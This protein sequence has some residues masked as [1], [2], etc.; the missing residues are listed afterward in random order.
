MNT[1]TNSLRNFR[2]CALAGVEDVRVAASNKIVGR[3]QQNLKPIYGPAK[4]R[5]IEDFLN[6]SPDLAGILRFTRKYGPLRDEPVPGAEFE[7]HWFPW[8]ADQRRLR[9][10]WER[11][12]VI[13][14]S[15]WESSGG[16]LACGDGWLTYTTS[17]LYSFLQV[18]L[19]TCEAKRL[20]VCKKPGCK[21][22]CF[23]TGDLKQRFCNEICAAWGQRE[24]KKQWW[25]E[26]GAAWREQRK[27]SKLKMKG[28]KNGA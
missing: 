10:L 17:S 21:N 2:F 23:I 13:Q 16:S 4:R 25:A 9:S 1:P 28:G 7:L 18:D 14:P 15:D 3:F 24:W 26:H 8:V 19:I 20:R 12:R 11:R 22:P 27:G 6:C 5:I